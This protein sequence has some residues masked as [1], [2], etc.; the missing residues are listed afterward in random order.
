MCPTDASIQSESGRVKE[1]IPWSCNSLY[2]RDSSS[3]F[4]IRERGLKS[5]R[6]SD[7][8][9]F[10]L[11]RSFLRSRRRQEEVMDRGDIW[12][13]YSNLTWLFQCGVLPVVPL[14]IFWISDQVKSHLF[15]NEK[16]DFQS[17]CRS[18]SWQIISRTDITGKRKDHRR[19]ELKE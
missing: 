10:P 2:E 18:R 12:T 6:G 8:K 15:W 5:E 16:S 4:S 11:E 3:S 19:S 17:G 7:P 14:S 1:G 9:I 13:Q